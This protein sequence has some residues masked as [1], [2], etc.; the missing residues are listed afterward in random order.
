[1]MNSSLRHILNCIGRSKIARL[2]SVKFLWLCVLK[3]FQKC[4]PNLYVGLTE[5]DHFTLTEGQRV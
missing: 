3:V 4:C 5:V 1:M 2:N